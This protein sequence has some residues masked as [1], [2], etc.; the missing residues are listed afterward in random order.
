MTPN[1]NWFV[2]EATSTNEKGTKM[3]TQIYPLGNPTLYWKV[4]GSPAQGKEYSQSMLAVS[5]AEPTET[6]LQLKL[7]KARRL[8]QWS[9]LQDLPVPA[10][11]QTIDV[12]VGQIEDEIITVRRIMSYRDLTDL[13]GF[14]D[15]RGKIPVKAGLAV[16]IEV[17]TLLPDSILEVSTR[18]ATDNEGR[19]LGDSGYSTSDGDKTRSKQENTR[20]RT[21][22]LPLPNPEIKSFEIRLKTT[23]TVWSGQTQ[24]VELKGIPNS[25]PPF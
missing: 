25:K 1:E 14:A 22:I 11:G 2:R 7:E 23:Q 4:D 9:R 20:L 16:V 18:T 5:D 6:N 24:L 12:P 8:V 3:N 17:S 13:P 15:A 19:D 10:A 21:I